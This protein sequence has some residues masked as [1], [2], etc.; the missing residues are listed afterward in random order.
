MHAGLGDLPVALL[1]GRLLNQSLDSA[2]FRYALANGTG[3]FYM[4]EGR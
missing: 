1:L 4:R 2:C 3:P